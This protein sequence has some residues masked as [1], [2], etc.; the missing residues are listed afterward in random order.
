MSVRTC[1]LL[2][3]YLAVL[4][5]LDASTMIYAVLRGPF[6]LA[7]ALGAPTAYLN[8][9]VHVPIA[10]SSYIVFAIA[11]VAGALYLWKR[12][13][14]YDRITHSAVIVGEAYGVFTI[15]TGMAWASESWGAAWNWDPRETGVLLLVLAY[16][17]YFALRSSIPDPERKK[18]VANAYAIAAFSMVPISFAAPYIF[19]SLHPSFK[20]AQTFMWTGSA[21]P[22]MASRMLL[23]ILTA[24]S[25]VLVPYKAR[26]AKCSTKPLLA[27]GAAFLIVVATAAAIIAAPYI[28]DNPVRAV[29][30]GTD[31]NGNITWILLSNGTNLTLQKPAKN[32]VKPPLTRQ[33]QSSLTG[34]IITIENG[35][36]RVVRHWCVPFNMTM[37]GLLILT[38]L[39]AQHHY[40]KT[41]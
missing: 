10:I 6:P 19:K 1:R 3:A 22:L 17:G 12:D 4:L 23:A 31:E 32:P 20:E 11:L 18:L 36:I 5:A 14:K 38:T 26:T 16:L 41:H 2:A 7:V 35:E 28:T 13:D 24:I 8:I 30:V 25:L 33:G 29:R 15:I 39:L 40:T 9:F 34:H 37:Y 27:I 21:A